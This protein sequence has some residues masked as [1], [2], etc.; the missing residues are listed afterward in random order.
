MLAAG[1]HLRV[2][3]PE[4]MP[5][6]RAIYGDKLSYSDRPYGAVEGADGLVIVTEWPE[7]RNPDFEI[8]RR[9]LRKPVIFD[10][11]NV[12]DVKQMETLGFTYYGI[13]RG[14]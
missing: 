7:F 14:K 8:I 2:H 5:N 13:G 12:Y 4:A 11:R 9:L 3:D 10:G 1:V 6:V